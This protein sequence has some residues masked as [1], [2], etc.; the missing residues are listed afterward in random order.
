MAKGP[1]KETACHPR[2]PN[3]LVINTLENIRWQGGCLPP[4]A[5]AAKS[6]HG[7]GTTGVQRRREF[8]GYA[9]QSMAAHGGRRSALSRE[10]AKA[11]SRAVTERQRDVADIEAAEAPAERSAAAMPLGAVAKRRGWTRCRRTWPPAADVLWFVADSHKRNVPGQFPGPGRQRTAA[12]Y[13][14]TLWGSTIGDGGLNFS[15]RNG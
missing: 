9:P 4:S 11:R 7:T 8:E 5:D 6:V 12:A 2:I 15:V 3:T 10:A 13:S 14:P 1:E